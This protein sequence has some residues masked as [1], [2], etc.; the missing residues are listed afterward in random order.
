VKGRNE[1]WLW[2]ARAEMRGP[3]YTTT[4]RRAPTLRRCSTRCIEFP[5]RGRQSRSARR[6]RSGSLIVAKVARAAAPR[7]LLPARWQAWRRCGDSHHL[8]ALPPA[9]QCRHSDAPALAAAHRCLMQKRFHSSQ[10]K[11]RAPSATGASLCAARSA[12]SDR[13]GEPRNAAW[14]PEVQRGQQREVI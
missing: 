5:A 6:L 4:V 14:A 7:A 1:S 2:P 9:Q 13:R 3:A 11:E 12:P 8:L 10:P